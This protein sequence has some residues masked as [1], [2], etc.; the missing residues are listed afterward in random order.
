MASLRSGLV[1]CLLSSL[2]FGASKREAA[3]KCVAWGHNIQQRDSSKLLNPE[4]ARSVLGGVAMAM[5]L[6]DE[7]INSEKLE[8]DA[9]TSRPDGSKC[10]MFNAVGTSDIHL[11]ETLVQVAKKQ[12][13][14]QLLLDCMKVAIVLGLVG[15]NTKNTKYE[16]LSFNMGYK[17]G[18]LAAIF[19]PSLGLKQKLEELQMQ[20][21]GN[22]EKYLNS[23]EVLNLEKSCNL[24]FGPY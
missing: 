4:Y 14:P 13:V 18:G 15:A 9:R 16:Q 24:F 22:T 2:C 1:V 7:K 23:E 5:A 11:L 3:I 8:S 10:Q 21:Y 20:S 19:N 6:S 12:N 17:L